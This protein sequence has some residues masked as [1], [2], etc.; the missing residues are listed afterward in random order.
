VDL[1]TC[2]NAKARVGTLCPKLSGATFDSLCSQTNTLCITKCLNDVTSCSDV[3]CAFCDACGCAT[4]NF[5]T[6]VGKCSSG[7]ATK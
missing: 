1:S 5:L 3:G 7:V 6:C 4:D 2:A